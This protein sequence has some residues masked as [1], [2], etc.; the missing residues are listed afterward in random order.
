MTG[1]QVINSGGIDGSKSRGSYRYVHVYV[2]AGRIITSQLRQPHPYL[3]PTQ[4]L[5]CMRLKVRATRGEGGYTGGSILWIFPAG[6]PEDIKED[7]EMADVWDVAST[8]IFEMSEV[9]QLEANKG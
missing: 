5:L 8:G 9:N 4:A 2:H 7:V 6:A 3:R 1:D